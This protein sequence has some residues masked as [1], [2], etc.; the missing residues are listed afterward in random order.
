MSH[1]LGV[2]SSSSW[3][4][5]AMKYAPSRRHSFT[6]QKY[7]AKKLSSTTARVRKD[8]DPAVSDTLADKR[9]R[10]KVHGADSGLRESTSAGSAFARHKSRSTKR[11][12]WLKIEKLAHKRDDSRLGIKDQSNFSSA[13]THLGVTMASNV[14]VSELDS[15]SRVMQDVDETHRE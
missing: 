12:K 2:K 1:I 13:Y 10:K 15:T 11:R 3:F 8:T 14:D 4:Y 9:G 6:G 5:R 7:G